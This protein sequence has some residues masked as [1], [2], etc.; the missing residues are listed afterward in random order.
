MRTVQ[1][2]IAGG[3]ILNWA[4]KLKKR[5]EQ[6]KKIGEKVTNVYKSKQF[7]KLMEFIPSSD[8]KA[9][10]GYEGEAHSLVKLGK[11]KWAVASFLGPGTR[12]VERLKRDGANSFRT[13]TDAA[14]EMHDLSY[15]LA[16]QAPTREEQIKL[17]R[18]ADERMIKTMLII[19]RDKLDY[20]VN[21]ALGLRLIQLKIIGEDMGALQKASFSG[22]LK[23]HS[24]ADV[25]IVEKAIKFLKSKG[26]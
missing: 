6:G 20:P 19:K 17:V 7:K 24:P 4:S 8:E 3:G 12:I 25:K 5:V 21:I 15:Y 13:P 18:E 22:D 26:Y 14:A 9:T 2:S 11:L 1:T 23:K 16:Q 10:I